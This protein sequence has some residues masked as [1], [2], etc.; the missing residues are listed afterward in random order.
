MGSHSKQYRLWQG[1]YHSSYTAAKQDFFDYF[2]KGTPEFDFSNLTNE[3]RT[4]ELR[5]AILIVYKPTIHL[6]FIAPGAYIKRH[7]CFTYEE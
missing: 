4:N 5:Y 7:V 1:H 6:C 2:P 3:G